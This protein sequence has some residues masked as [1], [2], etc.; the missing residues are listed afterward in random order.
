MTGGL[1]LKRLGNSAIRTEI[2]EK[3]YKKNWVDGNWKENDRKMEKIL[4]VPDLLDKGWWKMKMWSVVND[5]VPEN[6]EKLVNKKT[7]YYN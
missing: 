7:W 1:G 5:N 4:E 3:Y 2:A 6:P